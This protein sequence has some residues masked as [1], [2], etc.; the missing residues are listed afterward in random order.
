[1]HA[2]YVI[3]IIIIIIT[4]TMREGHV[5]KPFLRWAGGKTQLLSDYEALLPGT[6]NAYYEPFI[7]G[8]A[9][10]FA[11][12][13]KLPDMRCV[14]GDMNIDLMQTYKEVRSNAHHISSVLRRWQ[15]ISDTGHY[16]RLRAAYNKRKDLSVSAGSRDAIEQAARFIVLNKTCFNG[17]YRVSKVK[18]HF[19]VP[20]NG[21]EFPALPSREHLA[22]VA[23]A[24]RFVEF[25]TGDF[26]Q[27]VRNAA[28]HDLVFMDPPYVPLSVTARFTSYTPGGF[29]EDA[30]QAVATT[31]L[32]LNNRGVY[33]M[34]SNHDTPEVI[35]YYESLGIS[36]LNITRIKARRSINRDGGGRAPI[37]EV[38]IRNYK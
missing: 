29:N 14:V 8:G 19:N 23:H 20:W 21:A 31:F 10:L 25:K 1:M 22:R 15:R 11:L 3:I 6:W 2:G 37:M 5:P 38:L 30:Q 17:L 7:G 4:T 36:S 27:T 18:E 26:A 24:V 34:A 33:V 16:N 32:D 35:N 12:L 28:H 13:R 9:M